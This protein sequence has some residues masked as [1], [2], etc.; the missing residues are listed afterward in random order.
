M[1]STKKQVKFNEKVHAFH[2]KYKALAEESGLD[3]MASLEKCPTCAG[4][5]HIARI[6]IQEK[7]A[8]Q[9]FYASTV[10]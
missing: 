9:W 3:F 2:E 6:S 5:G 8:S 7:K 4:T 10:G 1:L